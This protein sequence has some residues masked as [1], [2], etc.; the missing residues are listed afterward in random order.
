VLSFI[1]EPTRFSTLNDVMVKDDGIFVL[2]QA[3]FG[4]TSRPAIIKYDRGLNYVGEFGR[5]STDGKVFVASTAPGDFYWPKRFIAQEND[6][7]Y[8]ID[9]SN[10]LDSTAADTFD[11]IIYINTELDPASWHTFPLT[12]PDSD[13]A[14][15]EP[16]RFFDT[17]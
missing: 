4:E 7:L 12:Q 14:S 16:F 1:K 9:D 8:I 15:G 10:R 17:P 2:N 5:I 3:S 6:G 11:K 13:G